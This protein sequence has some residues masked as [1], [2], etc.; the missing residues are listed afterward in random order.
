M[1]QTVQAAMFKQN[2]L[3][4]KETVLYPYFAGYYPVS[5]AHSIQATF[6]QWTLPRSNRMGELLGWIKSV[7]QKEKQYAN[8][9]M[10]AVTTAETSSLYM[11]KVIRL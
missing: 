6:R 8:L 5:Q 2:A 7:E 11:T 10:G 4:A 9:K 3:I 1:W